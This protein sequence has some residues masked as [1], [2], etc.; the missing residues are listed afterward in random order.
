MHKR[1]RVYHARFRSGGQLIRQRLSSDFVVAC[2]M[3]TD[4]RLKAYRRDQGELSNDLQIESLKNE[5]L[6]S[7]EQALEPT[8]VRRY[9][10]HLAHVTR[11][12]SVQNVAQLDLDVIEA[13]R[14]DRLSEDVAAK[15]VNKDVGALRRMLNWA[16]R[17]KKI[18]DNPLVGL[19][20]LPEISKEARALRPEE[21]ER[22]FNSSNPH[23][24]DIWYAYLTTG[25]RKME[26]SHLLFA[27]I[28]WEARELVVRPSSAKNKTARR[29][30]LDAELFDIISRQR[31]HAASRQP[32]SWADAA[33]TAQIRQRL[34]H[35]HVF[36]TT[37]NTPLGGNVYRAFMAS[38]GRAGIE[39]KT[40]D[41]QGHVVEFV[42]LHSTRHTFATDLILNGADPKTVQSLLGHRTLELTMKIYA[43]VFAEHKHAAIGKLSYGAGST[44]APD[45][46]PLP[47]RA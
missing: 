35:E 37:A 17:R 1:G 6:R 11:L 16:V 36:V 38:C 26:L 14:E 29:V 42:D 20:P 24:R 39:T 12:L 41:A 9:R 34:T 22:L 31:D 10:Q 47:Q 8:T 30:P 15:T 45:V 19:Q 3:L 28:D 25:L 5:W 23:W 7:V 13:F 18:G 2:E 33:T 32:G 27:D 44:Q 21:V 4:L 46:I 40:V 43:R